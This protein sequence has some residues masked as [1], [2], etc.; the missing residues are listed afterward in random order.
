MGKSDITIKNESWMC[1]NY[2][3][4]EIEIVEINVEKGF[5]S[6]DGG[7]ESYEKEPGV[8]D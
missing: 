5:S 7:N 1:D 4:P 6:S 8:W 3:S 2:S